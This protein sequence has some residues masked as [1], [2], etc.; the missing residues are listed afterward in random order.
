MHL[1]VMQAEFDHSDFNGYPTS[2]FKIENQQLNYATSIFC[3]SRN[4]NR[5]PASPLASQRHKSHI[6]FISVC[7]IPAHSASEPAVA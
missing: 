5:K 6:A 1:E 3:N 7:R 4:G 2:L